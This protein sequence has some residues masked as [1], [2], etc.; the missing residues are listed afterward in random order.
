MLL[1]ACILIANGNLRLR[2]DKAG[3]AARMFGEAST[4]LRALGQRKAT[5]S[6]D[7]FADDFPLQALAEALKARMEKPALFRADWVAFASISR[8]GSQ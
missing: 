6:S 5:A 8:P 7:G 2:M 3:S 1:R 4:K